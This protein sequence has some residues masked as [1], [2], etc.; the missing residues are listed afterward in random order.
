MSEY[1]SDNDVNELI[2]KVKNGDEKAWE[3]L[4]EN[5]EKYVH[6]CVWKRLRGTNISDSSR[7][8]MESDLY[9]AGWKG[10]VSA[11]KGFDFDK[12]KFLTYAT[13]YIDGEI[14]KELDF[15]FNP[16]GLKNRPTYVNDEGKKVKKTFVREYM[17]DE[18]GN[19]LPEAV[20]K[21]AN[22]SKETSV[23]DASEIR[24]YSA[25]RRVLQYLDVLRLMT[26]EDHQLT[27]DEFAR[28]IYLYR[29]AKY[30]TRYDSKTGLEAN[31][32]M[33]KTIEEMITELDPSEYTE[34]K[35][36][37]Y[38]IKYDG[39]KEDRIKKKANKE[40]GEKSDPITN[41]SYNHIFSNDE[42]DRLIQLVSFSDMLDIDDKNNLIKKLIA[43][44][45]EYY[46]TPFWDDKLRFNPKAVYGR[47]SS[48]YPKERTQFIKNL[49]VIQ[50]AVNNLVQ[51]SF[52][53]NQ[54]TEDH[55]MTPNSTY[56]HILSPYHLVVYHDNYYC[57]GL[58]QGNGDKRIWHY[59]VDLMSDLEIRK[60]DTGKKIPI[61]ISDFEG[62][63]ICNASWD[64]EKYM[65]E[66]LNMA[67]DEPQD[68]RIKIKNS[69]Y[70]II[71]DW[72]GD[73]YER[74]DEVVG[75]DDKGNEVKYDI[76]KVR[77]SP[78]MIVHW[79]MQYGSRVEILNE[80]IRKRIKIE[81]KKMNKIY[82]T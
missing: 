49:N 75:L 53:F 51:I 23:A 16:L 60:D 1:L 54:Y 45:S 3:M 25:E 41:F 18:E 67:Y 33:T 40:K 32:T 69:D 28:Q 26:D 48:R 2:A 14:S 80:E 52:K 61:E 57:I 44:A 82:G 66:H 9:Q 15:F 72:F 13:E 64:P 35:E 39:Y 24:E 27:K 34:D 46:R 62:T 12:V 63:P 73:H 37:E 47:L 71:H 74:V 19:I 21:L 76:V 36:Q 11:I 22:E 5:F 6:E 68:I 29:V 81:I 50:Y 17:E 55:K 4:Y 70:T 59:R 79:A 30:G 8:E 58:R 56:T 43:T 10:F 7:K 31:N 77:T 38:R 65:A 78:A 20:K 42:L